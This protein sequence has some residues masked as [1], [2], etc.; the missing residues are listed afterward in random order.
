M[1][2]FPLGGP[3]FGASA[4]INLA[5]YEALTSMARM[6]T[7][8]QMND[9]Y[10]SALEPLKRSIRK[11]L[12]SEEG[13]VMKMSDTSS[14]LGICQDVNAYAVTTGIAPPTSDRLI[15]DYTDNPTA[16]QGIKGWDKIS[17]ISPYATGFAAEAHFIDSDAQ[18]AIKLI[19]HVWSM[20]ADPSNGNYSGA[21]WEA[22]KPDG[23]P[24]GHDTSLAHGWSTW[25]T[26]LLPQYLGG[27][28][29]LEPGWKRW[30][31]RPLLAGLSEVDV[32]VNTVAGLIRM[33]LRIE[34][35]CGKGQI[36]VLVPRGTHCE[37]TAPKGWL[38]DSQEMDLNEKGELVI[39]GKDLEVVV[40][41]VNKSTFT[42]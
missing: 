39:E 23:T 27:L 11:H 32:A 40:Y 37:I 34:E 8:L 2:W 1:D 36:Q 42:A 41:I 16:Y 14:P 26:F 24:F 15:P 29:P 5:Y 31:V 19:K 4:K 12:W 38:L 10:T 35:R 21:H 28:T 20:M 13:K 33:S 7:A 6:S 3:V 25:P 9:C 17:I 18:A 22:M 30:C